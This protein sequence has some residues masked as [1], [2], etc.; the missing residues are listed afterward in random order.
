MQSL[1]RPTQLTEYP[2]ITVSAS[3]QFYFD[4][5]KQCLL[6]NHGVRQDERLL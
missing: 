1:L 5:L 6:D 3:P 2:D 4:L